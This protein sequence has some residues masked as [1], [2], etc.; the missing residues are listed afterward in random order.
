MQ[1]LEEVTKERIFKSMIIRGEEG[2]NEN[3]YALVYERE[4]FSKNL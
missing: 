2:R 1:R 4:F 3:N